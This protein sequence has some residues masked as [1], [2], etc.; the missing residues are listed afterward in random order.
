MA[1]WA[2][3]WRS[4]LTT[5]FS[6]DSR[7]WKMPGDAGSRLD[8]PELVLKSAAVDYYTPRITDLLLELE[9]VPIT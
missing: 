3:F 5:S 2:E 1:T 4:I 6:S 8:D 7:P 9:R